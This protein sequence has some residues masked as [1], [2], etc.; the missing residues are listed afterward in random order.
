MTFFDIF[1]IIF[2]ILGLLHA[3]GS[4]SCLIA[5]VNE[6]GLCKTMNIRTS[7]RLTEQPKSLNFKSISGVQERRGGGVCK[8]CHLLLSVE[9]NFV[10]WSQPVSHSCAHCPLIP[11]QL[12]DAPKI[13]C[14]Q[15]LYALEPASEVVM[16]LGDTFHWTCMCFASPAV[17]IHLRCAVYLGV[18][19]THAY[20]ITTV[21]RMLTWPSFG[22]E[23]WA[24]QGRI[25]RSDNRRGATCSGATSPCTPF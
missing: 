12:F 23:R 21:P 13:A 4:A 17:H 16:R 5:S 11:T 3:N 6:K 9:S 25:F 7:S 19:C 20:L 10:L 2:R 22:A 15:K 1:C 8:V 14:S 18:K 24:T